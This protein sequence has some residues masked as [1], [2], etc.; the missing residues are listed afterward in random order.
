MVGG[1]V[2]S[3][4]NKRLRNHQ[5][6]SLFGKEIGVRFEY[7]LLGLGEMIVLVWIIDNHWIHK[8]ESLLS[9]LVLK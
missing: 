4:K 7:F 3:A 5:Q 8:E 1:R 2:R 9:F 6:Q